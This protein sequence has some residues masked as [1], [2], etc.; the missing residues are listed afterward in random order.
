MP[1]SRT[2]VLEPDVTKRTRVANGCGA[3]V[4]R[5]RWRTT[6]AGIVLTVLA[7]VGAGAV[8]RSDSTHAVA[9]PPSPPRVTVSQPLQQTAQSTIRFLGQ[10]SAVDT[11]ELRAQ[12]GGTLTDIDFKDGQIVHKGDLLFVIDPRPFQIRLDQAI[13]QLNT[14]EG[15]ETL[16]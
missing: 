12:V 6:L 7:V 4:H 15:K 2:A 14:A 9:P 5:I 13:A 11:V 3:R 10:F 8:W 16:S 1:T